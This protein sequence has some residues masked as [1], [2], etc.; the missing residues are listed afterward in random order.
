MTPGEMLRPAG[1]AAAV[2]AGAAIPLL[3]EDYDSMALAKGGAER[4]N[5]KTAPAQITS[6][7]FLLTPGGASEGSLINTTF[8]TTTWSW[9]A[10]EV[11]NLTAQGAQLND[12]ALGLCDDAQ[13][14]TCIVDDHHLRLA[15]TAAGPHKL[16]LGNGSA[17]FQ[18]ESDTVR[19]LELRL[20]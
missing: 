2:P 14:E 10:N 20:R 8:G 6:L 5:I 9:Q 13:S 17:V 11:S 19:A 7:G 16:S 12:V 18:L 1:A 3:T 4:I 15:L